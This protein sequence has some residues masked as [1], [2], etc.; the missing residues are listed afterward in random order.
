MHGADRV[1]D[2]ELITAARAGDEQAYAELYRRHAS[3]ALRFARSLTGHAADADD[4]VAEAF[5]RVL[6]ALRSGNG[7]AEAFRPYLLSALRNAF[8]DGARRSGRE[9]PVEELTPWVPVVDPTAAADERRLIARAFQDLPERWQLVLWHTEVEGEQPADIAPL[10][11]ISANAVAALAY[12]AREGLRERYLHAHI[13]SAVDEKCR[14]TVSRLAAYTRNRLSR[15]EAARVRRHLDEC[16]R[17]RLLFGELAD[18]NS[19]LGALLGPVVLGGAATAYLA[20]RGTAGVIVLSTASS[21][22]PASA[23]FGRG[24]AVKVGAAVAAAASIMAVALAVLPHHSPAPTDP[25]APAAPAAPAAS[26]APVDPRPSDAGDAPVW[27]AA[28]SSGVVAS[29]EPVGELTPGQEGTLVL[30]VTASVSIKLLGLGP[31]TAT[32]TLPTGITLLDSDE[33]DGWS[34]SGT[35]T[36]VCVLAQLAVGET[37]QTL[38]KVAVAPSASVGLPLLQISV[39]DVGSSTVRTSSGAGDG[40]L[41]GVT[42]MS[43]PARVVTAG[44]SLLSCG[45]LALT[46]TLARSGAGIV[47]VDNDNYAMEPYTELLAP[48][49]A[50]YGSAVSGATLS[51]G[52]EVRWAGLY[53]A[54]TGTPPTSPTAYVRTPSS[55]GYQVVSATRVSQVSAPWLNHPVY[56]AV[57]DVTELA[58]AAR[59]NGQWWVAV[60]PSAFATGPGT[61]AGWALVAIVDDGGPERT[62]AVFDGLVAVSGTEPTSARLTGLTSGSASVGLVAWEGDR[63]RTGDLVMLDGVAL[64]APSP[65][66][67]LTSRTNGTPARWNT[68][69]TDAV[70]LTGTAQNR[71]PVVSAVAGSDEWL[72]GALVIATGP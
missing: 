51:L 44:N 2:G 37:A 11:G 8:Y 14:P 35:T 25:S 40:D 18:V 30:T 55:V 42:I 45:L 67:M 15:T 9:H 61:F 38:L 36:V 57:A 24:P 58:R 7:P 27:T 64:D 50:P 39:P 56:Q 33:G 62:V 13:G 71:D 65:D 69:G 68:F 21:G 23:V 54:G 26:T 1:T 70:V 31:I 66:N 49:G 47:D 63:G 12:R 72:L 3:A 22:A 43:A 52:G 5:T 48:L 4:L 19:R 53:W 46:C 6:A 28:E 16:D 59:A 41:G 60:P 10:L 32:V 20:A 34:C 17:C 29:V